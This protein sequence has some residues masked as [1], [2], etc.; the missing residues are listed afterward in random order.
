M[1][2]R[3]DRIQVIAHWA[4]VFLILAVTAIPS[5]VWGQEDVGAALE[6]QFT[7]TVRPFL[8]T[9]CI[10]CHGQQHPAAQMDLSGFTT[11]GEIGRAHV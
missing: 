11:M 4:S 3:T 2:G 7:R 6:S 1:E 9:Y 5:V 10:G 8:E